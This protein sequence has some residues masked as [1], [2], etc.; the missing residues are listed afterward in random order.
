MDWAEFNNIFQNSNI[1]SGKIVIND[2]LTATLEFIKNNYHFELLK[3]ITAVDKQANGIE[4]NYHL[5]S[6]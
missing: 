2:N 1:E 3:D 6:L 5:Y 4:L